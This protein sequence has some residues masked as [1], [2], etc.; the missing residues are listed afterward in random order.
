[1]MNKNDVLKFWYKD[2]FAEIEDKR[3]RKYDRLPTEQDLSKVALS[4]EEMKEIWLLGIELGVPNI[5][6]EKI[7]M[8]SRQNKR[9]FIF[10]VLME[11]RRSKY[12]ALPKLR[13]TIRAV[14]KNQDHFVD[15]YDILDAN[16]SCN[17]ASNSG[18]GC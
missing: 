6:M 14:Q 12:E 3:D 9:E 4:L 2:T 11:W 15:V 8:D 10:S 1:V 5:K 17:A 18:L 16:D 13:K 7:K